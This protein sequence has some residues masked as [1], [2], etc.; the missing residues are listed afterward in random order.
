LH[1]REIEFLK[2][3]DTIDA[4]IEYYEDKTGIPLSPEDAE[5][6]LARGGISLVDRK[7]HDALD[8]KNDI[9]IKRARTFIENNYKGPSQLFH[10]A[11]G[12]MMGYQ[13]EAFNPTTAQY[14]DFSDNLQGYKSDR[15]YYRRN[16]NLKLPDNTSSSEYLEGAGKSTW[17]GLVDTVKNPGDALI[18]VPK[19]RAEL[20][21]HPQDTASGVYNEF[22]DQDD[23]NDL[24]GM[25]GDY[26]AQKE[27]YGQY[28]PLVAGA[29]L[30]RGGKKGKKNSG[31]NSN[32]NVKNNS[33]K[34]FEKEISSLPPGERVARIKEK[35]QEVVKTHKLNK[36][37]TLS[38]K[39]G[40]DV[41]TDASGNIYS[42]DTQHGRFEKLNKR[43]QYISEV[44]FDLNPTGKVD[45]S[46][47]HNLNVK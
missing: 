18:N 31:D 17:N 28:I 43:G 29:V 40:R 23:M 42:V 44:D 24:Y 36:D 37:K 15:D 14:N 25:V 13:T 47:G 32:N 21:M 35:V 39:T 7:Y 9:T 19:G 20:I 34:D 30:G 22:D 16:L 45:T 11:N 12:S 27:S 33:A 46:G 8:T 10:P 2:D 5:K 3:K 6:L 41:Y 38:K 1:Q 26:E 4:F